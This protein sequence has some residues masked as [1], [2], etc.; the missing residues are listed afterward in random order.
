MRL[1]L[2]QAPTVEPILL[3]E[4][5]AHLR[6]EVDDDDALIAGLIAAARQ[7]VE[8]KTGRALITQ[9]WDAQLDGGFTATEYELP[10]APLQSVVS[11]QYTDTAGVLQSW[12]SSNY[13]VT[14]PSGPMPAAGRLSLAY[15]VG[16]P[17]TRY[18]NGAAVIRFV[19]GYGASGAAVP[20]AIKLALRLMLGHW[21]EHRESVVFG[22]NA[23]EVPLGV[24][25]LLQPYRLGWL[26]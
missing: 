14:A 6:V 2:V 21:Y 1:S 8:Q 19:A 3:A 12:D 15:G 17:S 10:L 25:A 9:V 7:Y 13:R 20:E 22:P 24:E 26:F 16:W 4:A 23:L 11:V 18:Q 5:K